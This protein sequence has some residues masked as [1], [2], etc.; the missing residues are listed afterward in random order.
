MSDWKT[1]DVIWVTCKGREVEGAVV[2][3]SPNAV[4]LFIEMDAILDGHVGQMPI[5]RGDDGIYRSIVNNVEVH[6][7]KRHAPISRR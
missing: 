6:L 4:S 2:L 5:M 1:G 7:R 3:A